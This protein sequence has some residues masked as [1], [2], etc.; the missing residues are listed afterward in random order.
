MDV[1]ALQSKRKVRS[2]SP[3]VVGKVVRVGEVVD[4]TPEGRLVDLAVCFLFPLFLG[5][6]R[7]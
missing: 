1:P 7:N 6:G 3:I 5:T 4:L 2:P